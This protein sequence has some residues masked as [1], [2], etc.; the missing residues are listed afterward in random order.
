MQWLKIIE[1]DI[2]RLDDFITEYDLHLI[3]AKKEVNIGPHLIMEARRLPQVVDDIFCRLQ[4]IEAIYEIVDIRL[5]EVRSKYH[6][7]YLTNYNHKIISRDV[8]RFVEGEPEFVDMMVKKNSVNMLRNK[9]ASVTKGLEYK[10]F[11]LTNIVKLK[12]AG[13]DDF[14]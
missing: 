10:H 11:Q 8:E 3:E 6:R 5:K 4:E 1:K 14:I 2:N 9:F 7:H 13:I 12:A